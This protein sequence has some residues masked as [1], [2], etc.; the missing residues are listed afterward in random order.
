ME[1]CPEM[2]R[3][4]CGVHGI[5]FKLPNMLNF[6]EYIIA[7]IPLKL[8]ETGSQHVVVNYPVCKVF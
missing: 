3:Q 6:G 7:N 8:N 5:G 2:G 4:D 1:Q